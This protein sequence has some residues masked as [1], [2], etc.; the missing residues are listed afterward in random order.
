VKGK[1]SIYFYSGFM[2]YFLISLPEID[3]I[4]NSVPWLPFNSATILL[5]SA[6]VE[7]K[8]CQ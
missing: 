5:L 2:E 3:L 8:L 4:L 6:L 1:N 7:V